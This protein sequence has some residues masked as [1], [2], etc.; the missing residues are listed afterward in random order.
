[1]LISGQRLLPTP[2]QSRA[3]YRCSC[4]INGH[5]LEAELSFIPLRLMLVECVYIART[6]VIESGHIFSAA[7]DFILKKIVIILSNDCSSRDEELNES[8]IMLNR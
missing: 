6:I 1:M 7:C 2:H 8:R 5:I 3:N 4:S